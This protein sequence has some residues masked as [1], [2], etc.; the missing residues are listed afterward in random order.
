MKATYKFSDEEL[1][2]C[3]FDPKADPRLTQRINKALENDLILSMRLN[4]MQAFVRQHDI[5]DVAA[6]E[7]QREIWLQDRYADRDP[8]IIEATD[9][10]YD[11]EEMSDER[12]LNFIFRNSDD[13]ESLN[14]MAEIHQNAVLTERYE[15]MI[16]FKEKNQLT[17]VE[18][19]QAATASIMQQI[20]ERITAKVKQQLNEL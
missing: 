16:A 13:D 19:F 17:S 3:V 10:A 9:H 14:L 1:L 2:C 6:Y 5:K 20:A 12:L 11:P 7:H 8:A 18:Q 4:W 15:I